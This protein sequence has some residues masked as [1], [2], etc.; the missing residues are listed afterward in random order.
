MIDSFERAE[1]KGENDPLSM[2]L[3]GRKYYQGQTFFMVNYENETACF[4]AGYSKQNN[5]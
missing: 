4:V 1:I 2:D 3:Y 5:T